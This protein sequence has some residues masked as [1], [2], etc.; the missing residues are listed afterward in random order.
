MSYGSRIAKLREQKGWTQEELSELIGISR[1]S[2]SH[3]EK[4][5]REPNLETLTKLAD[6]FQTTIDQIIGR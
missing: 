5:R 3:Y 4:N 6:V 1:A 2:L